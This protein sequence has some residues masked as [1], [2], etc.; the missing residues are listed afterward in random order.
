MGCEME[1]A[2]RCVLVVAAAVAAVGLRSAEAQT[3]HVVGDSLGWDV[4]QNG[5]TAYTNWASTRKFTVRDILTFNFTT[6]QHDVQEVA[7]A[8]YDACTS[9]NAIGNLITTGPANVTLSTAGEHYYICT[10]GQHCQRGQK[11]T[12][13][14][15]AADGTPSP[16]SSPPPSTTPATPSPGSGRHTPADCAPTPTPTSSNTP[17]STTP[18]TSP[19]SSSYSV[20]SSLFISFASIVMGLFL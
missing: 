4:P 14:V 6:N 18:A 19:P 17:S 20:G 7:K 15:L 2:M 11:L 13:N 12:V 5:A 16:A 10:I 1:L 8:S 3:V 9:S